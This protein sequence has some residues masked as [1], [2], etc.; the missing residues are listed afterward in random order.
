MNSAKIS[1]AIR[2]I[3]LIS[4]RS[5]CSLKLFPICEKK[6]ILVKYGIFKYSYLDKMAETRSDSVVNN[7]IFLN[8]H[9]FLCN[10]K[11]SE[12][13]AIQENPAKGLLHFKNKKTKLALR[14]KRKRMGER[15]SL[16][17]R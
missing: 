11:E 15:V 5:V 17:Y 13:S 8:N 1:L 16:R 12:Q 3:F 6:T 7:S 10:L 2:N 9:F 14:R 4:K